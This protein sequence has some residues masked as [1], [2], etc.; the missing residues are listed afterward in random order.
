VDAAL[1]RAGGANYDAG[2]TAAG[3]KAG[4]SSS[5]KSASKQFFQKKDAETEV[6]GIQFEKARTDTDARKRIAWRVRACGGADAFH[7][8]LAVSS[9]ARSTRARTSLS[10]PATWAAAP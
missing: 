4:G 5:I 9:R 2:N 10:A 8:C 6:K 3:V 7:V 1:A